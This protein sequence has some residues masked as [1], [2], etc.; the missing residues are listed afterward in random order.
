MPELTPKQR[1]FIDE[2][3]IDCNATQAAIRAGYS[4]KSAK[5]IGQENLTKPQIN[6]AIK[7]LMDAKHVATI[8]TGDEVLSFLTSVMRGEP[9]EYVN[10][11]VKNVD[12]DKKETVTTGMSTPQIEERIDAAKELAKRHRLYDLT[13]LDAERIRK[14]KADA[15]IS[16]AKAKAL[17]GAGDKVLDKVDE[18]IEALEREVENDGAC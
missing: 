3:I 6:K 15:D 7:E 14:A 5:K 8:A 17:S 16:E 1:R 2:Y 11:K 10:K 9:Q 18:Y 12:G 13:D 4:K